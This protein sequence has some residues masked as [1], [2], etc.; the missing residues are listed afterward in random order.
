MAGRL[1]PPPAE[2][3]GTCLRI[4]CIPTKAWAQTA[5]A[6]RQSDVCSTAVA[7]AF[8]VHS[9]SKPTRIGR[10]SWKAGADGLVATP[11]KCRHFGRSHPPCNCLPCRSPDSVRIQSGNSR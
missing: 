5:L 8:G 7:A 6:L 3:D 10:N 4:G 11:A 1:S 2:L 9:R